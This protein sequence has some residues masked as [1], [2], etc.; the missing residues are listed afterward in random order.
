MQ[1]STLNT[2]HIIK[3]RLRTE[4]QPIHNWYRFILGYPPHLVREYLQKF[5]ADPERDWVFDPFCGTGT[6][7]LEARLQGYRSLAV[8]AN[9][10]TVLATG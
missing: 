6:T 10:M 2:A 4:D 1:E 7:P 8:D 9:P 3:N 5:E